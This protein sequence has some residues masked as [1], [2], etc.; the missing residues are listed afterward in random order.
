MPPRNELV[1]WN[2]N[3][4]ERAS[5]YER[6][7]KFCCSECNSEYGCIEKKSEPVNNFSSCPNCGKDSLEVHIVGVSS[8]SIH[9]D[10]NTIGQLADSNAKKLGRYGREEKDREAKEKH[11][12]ARRGLGLPDK[13]KVERMNKINKMTP[14][15]RRRY[16]N[17]GEGL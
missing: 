5:Y 9:G 4:I 17:T 10:I 14:E 16:I 1:E 11:K 13:E 3:L 15:Q 12:Q 7:R 8:F 6:V 2:L